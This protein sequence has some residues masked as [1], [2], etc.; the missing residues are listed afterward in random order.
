PNGRIALLYNT[1][2]PSTWEKLAATLKNLNLHPTAIYW[3][4]GE[5]PGKLARSKLRGLHII[6]LT[7]RRPKPK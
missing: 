3:L 1:L 7:A 5:T 2:N 4:P 6:I